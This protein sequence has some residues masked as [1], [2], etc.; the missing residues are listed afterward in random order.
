MR[1]LFVHNDYMRPSGEEHAID[2]LADLLEKN[3]HK[4]A[5][6]RRSSTEMKGKPLKKLWAFFSGIYN[7]FAVWE[8]RKKLAVFRPDIVQIQNLYPFISPAVIRTIKREGIPIVMRCPNY[9]LFCP[10][11]LHLDNRGEI[12][13]KCT[14]RGREL[15]CVK[16]N[17]EKDIL[18]SL[19]YALRGFTARKIWDIHKTIDTYIVQTEFQ[20]QKFVHNGIAP[21]KIKIVH[22]LTPKIKETKESEIGDVVSFVGRVSPEKGIHEFLQAAQEL[23]KIP[24]AVVGRIDDAYKYLKRES[25][26]NVKWCGFLRGNSLYWAY[27]RSRIIVVPGKWYEGFPNVITRAM[28]HG[29]PV[30]TGNIGA[31]ASIVDHAKNGLLVEPGN[32]KALAKAIDQLYFNPGLCS[33]YGKNGEEKAKMYSE[34]QIYSNLISIYNHLLD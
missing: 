11:G 25:P 23:P 18:K 24:F 31:M 30:I 34:D 7:P 26:R 1:I 27:Q 28:G 16:K 17:C 14:K 12:C 9:R 2:A 33:V 15:N 8:I 22:G 4:V 19:G 3:G 13:E 20:K 5:W 10:N 32:G 21:T 29:K 6:Y